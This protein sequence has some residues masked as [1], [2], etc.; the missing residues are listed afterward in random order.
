MITYDLKCPNCRLAHY[1]KG[2]TE[3]MPYHVCQNCGIRFTEREG[4]AVT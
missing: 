3:T 2:T 1:C 4:E